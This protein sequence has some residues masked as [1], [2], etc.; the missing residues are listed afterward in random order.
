MKKRSEQICFSFRSLETKS[1]CRCEDRGGEGRQ[2]QGVGDAE[3]VG[4]EYC[5]VQMKYYTQYVSMCTF[6]PQTCD[7]LFHCRHL[8]F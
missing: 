2:D 4:G 1:T 6:L 3:A 8:W 5:E 7:V